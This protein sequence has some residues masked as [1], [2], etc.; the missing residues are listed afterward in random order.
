M[1]GLCLAQKGSSLSVIRGRLAPWSNT[2]PLR[3]L[4]QAASP[5]TFGWLSLLMCQTCAPPGQDWVGRSKDEQHLPGWSFAPFCLLDPKHHPQDVALPDQMAKNR[6]GFIAQ[7]GKMSYV[8]GRYFEIDFPKSCHPY[9]FEM[10]FSEST[11]SEWLERHPTCIPQVSF[12]ERSPCMTS[13]LP[14]HLCLI[15]P[16]PS[17]HSWHCQHQPL[18]APWKCNLSRERTLLPFSW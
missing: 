17:I 7:K 13:P 18:P 15:A 10:G 11:S 8:L 3:E 16:L 12:H 4:V 1:L 14:P 2:L 6:F 9:G 5:T